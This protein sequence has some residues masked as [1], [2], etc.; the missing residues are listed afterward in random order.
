M[1]ENY[2]DGIED[3]E[4]NVDEEISDEETEEKKSLM[5]LVFGSEE[6]LA[7]DMFLCFGI[8]FACAVFSFESY[9]DD[10]IM[11]PVRYV[12]FLLMAVNWMRASFVSGKKRRGGFMLFTGIYWIVPAMLALML[13][14]GDA[15]STV[16][17]ML[18]ETASMLVFYPFTLLSDIFQVSEWVFSVIM[19]VLVTA[20]YI[21]SDRIN[22]GE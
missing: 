14:F 2:A 9:V 5:S 1:T 18:K 15:D 12:T 21:I 19:V 4:E 16:I 22:S 13:E 20:A 6:T 7:Q 11:Q 17:S 3:T 8:T 10:R